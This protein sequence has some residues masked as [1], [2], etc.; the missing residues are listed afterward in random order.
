MQLIGGNI[1]LITNSRMLNIINLN[2]L[3]IISSQ[4]TFLIW[5][6]LSK[7]I[8]IPKYLIWSL[9]RLKLV[10]SILKDPIFDQLFTDEVKDKYEVFSIL[11]VNKFNW[12]LFNIRYWE[13]I[14]CYI[15]HLHPGII[16]CIMKFFGLSLCSSNKK[17][18][19]KFF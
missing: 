7:P 17:G 6:S 12:N 5:K 14:F 13:F 4:L 16:S 9:L 11:N 8:I 18:Q 2:I 1:H 10:L 19:L 15:F 3:K